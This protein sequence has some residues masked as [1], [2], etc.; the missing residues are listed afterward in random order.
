MYQEKGEADRLADQI[1]GVAAI[2]EFIG[3]PKRR[4]QHMVETGAIPCWKIGGRW[5]SRKSTLRAFMAD[6]ESQAVERAK[7]CDQAR[8]VG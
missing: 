7:S 1:R 8:A 6:L 3:E 5:Y 2:A 4:T